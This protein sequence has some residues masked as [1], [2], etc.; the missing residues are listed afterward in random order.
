[1]DCQPYV[2]VCLKQKLEENKK[3]CGLHT[4]LFGFKSYPGSIHA[5]EVGYF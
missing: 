4:I 5:N 1:M 3:A 2:G